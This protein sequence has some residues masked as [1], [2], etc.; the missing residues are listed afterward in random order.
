MKLTL[1]INADTLLKQTKA[2]F[3]NGYCVANAERIKALAN[4]IDD[5]ELL[6]EL[7]M[8]ACDAIITPPKKKR[9]RP[10]KRTKI[11][12]TESGAY[13]LT[14]APLLTPEES[15]KDLRALVHE[16][17]MIEAV[18]NELE[19]GRL[20]DAAFVKVA[21][22]NNISASTLRDIYYLHQHK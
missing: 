13:D 8:L 6:R 12:L 16:F 14:N 11:T 1:D 20:L 15:R 5:P 9:G 18:A 22:D 19:K 4:K 3:E 2:Y 17:V 21:A 7:L 10:S